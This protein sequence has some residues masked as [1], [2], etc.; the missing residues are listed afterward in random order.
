[1]TTSSDDRSETPSAEL[2]SVWLKA[3][4][5]RVPRE[6]WTEAAARRAADDAAISAGDQALAAPGGVRDLLEAFFDTAENE[7]RK[8]ISAED[9]SDMRVHEKVAFGVR[10][11]LDTLAANRDAVRRASARAVWPF[12]AGDAVQRAWS[13]ADMVWDEAGDTAED[14]NRYTKRGL[15]T[16]VI[17]PI[18]A[19]WLTAPDSDALDAFIAKRL[20]RAMWVGK[21][22]GRFV[23]PVLDAVSRRRS[24]AA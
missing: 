7:T 17:P 11:W 1:M 14:Y 22:G 23:K 12:A 10:T 13:V 15:L 20:Q 24:P 5:P 8:A 16:A 21:T 4:L 9:L 6:G 19:Y 3:L 18:I 2:R